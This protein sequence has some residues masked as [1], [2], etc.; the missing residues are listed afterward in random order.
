[1]AYTRWRS[2]I[3]L[4]PP[5][6]G[7]Y[8]RLRPV[9]TI[10]PPMRCRRHI[11]CLLACGNLLAYGSRPLIDKLIVI[12]IMSRRKLTTKQQEF[13]QFL[14]DYVKER[15]EWPSYSVIMDHFGYQSPHSVTQN[16]KA[17]NK[18]GHLRRRP[19]DISAHESRYCLAVRHQ[20]DEG[21]IPVKGVISAGTLE[22]AI[23]VNMG[24]ITLDY[25]FPDLDRIFALRVAGDSMQGT[26]I[27]DGDYVLLMDD[28]IPEGGIGAVLYNGE[29]SLKR[30]YHDADKGLRLEP[31]N[32]DYD[33]IHIEPDVFEEVNVIGRY[34][35]HLSTETGTYKRLA[36]H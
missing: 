33:D 17:L 27:Q 2:I 8:R 9:T 5:F 22:E 1:M 19:G 12:D 23:E 10:A 20:S 13:L 7:R 6:R 31:A 28:D 14:I 29:T 32:P 15:D 4:S 34:V 21:N 3:V 16:L 36:P 18:K 35:G 25:I 30:V 26:G 24:S 11:A